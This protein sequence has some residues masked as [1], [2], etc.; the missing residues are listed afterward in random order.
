MVGTLAVFDALTICLHIYNACKPFVY[1]RS[2]DRPQATKDSQRLLVNQH[3][4]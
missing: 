2:R 4:D 3:A 1:S